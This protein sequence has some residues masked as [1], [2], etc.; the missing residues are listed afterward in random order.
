MELL[1]DNAWNIC[2]RIGLGFANKLSANYFDCLRDCK[3]ILNIDIFGSM[4]DSSYI[5]KIS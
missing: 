3:I 5:C 4:A 2:L 1:F